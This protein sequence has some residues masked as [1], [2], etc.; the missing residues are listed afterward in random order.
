LIGVR[1]EGVPDLELQ[2]LDGWVGLPGEQLMF[3]ARLGGA[4]FKVVPDPDSGAFRIDGP[5][6]W[7]SE[8]TVTRGFGDAV[9]ANRARRYDLHDESGRAFHP[10]F[11]QSVPLRFGNEQDVRLKIAVLRDQYVESPEYLAQTVR[12][13]VLT[14]LNEEIRRDP[15]MTRSRC[16]RHQ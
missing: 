2:G 8:I 3:E 6:M 15:L 4:E 7:N 16:G 11:R 14:Q 12:Q 9:D 1:V 5:V 10:A 13:H